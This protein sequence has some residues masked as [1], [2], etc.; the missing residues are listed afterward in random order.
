MNICLQTISTSV[1][2]SLAKLLTVEMQS[3]EVSVCLTSWES[4]KL[5]STTVVLFYTPTIY[6][7]IAPHPLQI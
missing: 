4:V 6:V 7:G 5:F 3:H 2:I 1:S